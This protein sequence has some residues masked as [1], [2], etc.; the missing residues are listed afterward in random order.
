MSAYDWLELL[1]ELQKLEMAINGLNATINLREAD[2][3]ENGHLLLNQ[4]ID[5][6]DSILVDVRPLLEKAGPLIDS[7]KEGIPRFLGD[8]EKIGQAAE[9]IQKTFNVL[10]IL[11][12]TVVFFTTAVFLIIIGAIVIIEY[13]RC[14]SP[15][16]ASKKMRK[17]RKSKFTPMLLEDSELEI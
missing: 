12:L 1:T 3:V 6:L 17:M 10:G 4:T 11:K 9:A 14:R 7:I 5:Y 13:R 16:F 2:L 15:S 8:A